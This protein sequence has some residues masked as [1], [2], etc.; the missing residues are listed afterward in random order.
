MCVRV[1]AC[2]GGSSGAVK[3]EKKKK[4]RR[5]CEVQDAGRGLMKCAGGGRGVCHDYSIVFIRTTSCF[6]N[7][8]LPHSA[9]CHSWKHTKA[10]LWDTHTS[11]TYQNTHTNTS[12]TSCT[13]RLDGCRELFIKVCEDDTS[14]SRAGSFTYAKKKETTLSGPLPGKFLILWKQKNIS[15]VWP[16]LCLAS[17]IVRL[18]EPSISVASLEN[19]RLKYCDYECY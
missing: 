13:L 10:P 1:C 17:R 16:V 19:I 11:Y 15:P 18:S 5:E 6:P 14:E 9:V 8:R 2:V 12:S 4:E 7:C 3:C